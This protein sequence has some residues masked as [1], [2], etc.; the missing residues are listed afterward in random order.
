MECNRIRRHPFNIYNLLTY[1]SGAGVTA[2]GPP[3][4]SL[5]TYEA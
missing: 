1:H 4:P 5:E 3:V 2:S